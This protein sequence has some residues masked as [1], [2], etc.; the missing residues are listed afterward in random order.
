MYVPQDVDRYHNT[1]ASKC[2]LQFRSIS[3]CRGASM[4]LLY[5]AP[6]R[7]LLY[8]CRHLDGVVPPKAVF[9]AAS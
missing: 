1:A 8:C 2:G 4:L 9:H 5:R 6:R 7:L 3:G